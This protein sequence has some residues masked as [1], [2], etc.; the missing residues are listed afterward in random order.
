MAEHQVL[1]IGLVQNGLVAEERVVEPGCPVT[2]GTDA[3]CTFHLPHAVASE[4]GVGASFTLFEHDGEHYRLRWRAGFTGQLG[5]ARGVGPAPDLE[6]GDLGSLASH[7]RGSPDGVFSLPLGPRHKGKIKLGAS[8][9]LFHFVPA[10]PPREAPTH[11]DDTMPDASLGRWTSTVAFQSVVQRLVYERVRTILDQHW[12]RFGSHPTQPYFALDRGS[13]RAV[14]RID[15]WH[16]QD[17]IVRVVSW[18]V[19]GANSQDPELMRFLLESNHTTLFGAFG[20]DPEGDIF[21][22]H[23]IVGLT[24]DREE[25]VA[26]VESVL[27]IADEYDDLIQHRWGGMRALDA[28]VADEPTADEELPIVH[29]FSR[30][31]LAPSGDATIRG[32]PVTVST[33]LG[34]LRSGKSEE[35]IRELHPDLEPDDI[36]QARDY[37]AYLETTTDRMLLG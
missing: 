10:R 14:I 12:G 9:F 35:Q 16:A 32:L 28:L 33:I 34:L 3:A 30:L 6:Q 18:V 19:T 8:Y 4:T 11:I 25:L 27:A 37:G 31:R 29:K 26:S 20:I 15:P 24:C 22:G 23:S 13:A 1:R 7:R 17:A 5:I 36:R 21:F 2:V